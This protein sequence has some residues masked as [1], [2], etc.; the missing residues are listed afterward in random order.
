MVINWTVRF[1]NPVWW[2]Q[3]IA[4]LFLPILTYFGLNWGDMTSWSAIGNLLVQAIGN[5]VVVV[6]VIVSVYNTLI[7]PTT[8]GLSDSA[9]ALTYTEPQ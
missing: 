5:P 2:A 1:K 3:L 9:R 7:D 6:S 4:S 8:V